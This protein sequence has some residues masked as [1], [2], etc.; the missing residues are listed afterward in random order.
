MKKARKRVFQVLIVIIIL[1]VIYY[2]GYRRVQEAKHRNE[3][4]I[5]KVEKLKK[6]NSVLNKKL[7]LLQTDMVYIEKRA[8]EK[9]GIARKGAILYEFVPAKKGTESKKKLENTKSS[10]KEK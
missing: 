3:E 4:L 1:G 9:L 10:L 6:E 8:R 7:E 5:Q 2:P